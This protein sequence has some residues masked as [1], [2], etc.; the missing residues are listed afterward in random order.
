MEFKYYG[1]FVNMEKEIE[2]TALN[3]V[4]KI[5]SLRELVIL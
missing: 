3:K 4:N 5:L 1:N 2:S